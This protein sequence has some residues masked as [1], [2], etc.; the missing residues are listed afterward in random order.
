MLGITDFVLLY[1]TLV[2]DDV[3]PQGYLADFAKLEGP[4][5]RSSERRLRLAI[6]VT[7]AEA[8]MS[9]EME[10]KRKFYSA[11]ETASATDQLLI[12]ADIKPRRFR[13]RW[14]QACYEGPTARKTQS[15]QSVLVG[16]LCL[17]TYSETLQ[18]RW[19]VC[20]ERAQPNSQ[21][22]GGGRRAGTLRSRVRV[23]QKFLGWLALA[24]NLVYPT[25][26]KQLIEYMQVR[27]SEPCVRG[28]LKLIHLSYV[29]MQEVACV[30]DKLTD[31]ALYDVTKKELQRQLYRADSLVKLLVSLAIILAARIM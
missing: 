7:D 16:S 20:S 19:A 2:A 31:S 27:L 22:L 4:V 28:S 9:L 14:Q 18:L 1:F 10:K 5:R 21:L 8:E 23:I 26:W 29:F 24:H 12:A 17:L 6:S 15:R 30:D 13:S 11:L 25:H 3:L